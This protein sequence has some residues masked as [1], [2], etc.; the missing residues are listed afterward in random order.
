MERNH[1]L[2][3]YESALRR[4]LD[5]ILQHRNADGSFGDVGKRKTKFFKVPLALHDNG[6]AAEAW[7][8]MCW[9][10]DETFTREG[11]F[12]DPRPGY[13]AA[14]WPYR[15]L[16]YVRAAHVLEMYDLSSRAMGYVMTFRNP[17]TGGIRAVAPYA[18][19]AADP[20]EDLI[21]TAFAGLNM[22]TLGYRPEAEAAGDWVCR[23]LDVQPALDD[24]LYLMRRP[25]TGVVEDVP[26]GHDPRWY[27]VD[28]RALGQ[29]YY[30]LGVAIL[31]LS[32]LYRLTNRQ[33]F[34]DGALGYHQFFQ[35]CREDRLQSVSS[36]KL[37]YGLSWL[38]LATGESLYLEEAQAAADYLVASQGLEGY[39]CQH[40]GPYLN[41]TAEY[42]FELRWFI[43]VQRMS[44]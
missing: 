41:I 1:R 32:H 13:H 15:N 6:Y 22:V 28:R 5:W 42:A 7:T 19:D 30:N 8:H 44:T 17:A 10:Q 23:L 38:H 12:D 2:A 39:W 40:G 9:L 31:F 16:W 11:D 20:R 37:L 36:G 4:G 25:G 29:D 27:A 24:G 3:A 21:L 43:Q 34:L 14:H 35:S 18:E 33:R 26:E